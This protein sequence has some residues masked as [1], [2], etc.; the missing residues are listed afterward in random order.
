[1]IAF[2][3]E[4]GF[5]VAYVL[6]ATIK[7]NIVFGLK[8]DGSVDELLDYDLEETI[9]NVH[10]VLT[11]DAVLTA[12]EAADIVTFI[13][14]NSGAAKTIVT[15]TTEYTV[16]NDPSNYKIN[17]DLWHKSNARASVK[18]KFISSSWTAL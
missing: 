9:N 4:A 1:M 3:G 7:C 13:T 15:D 17:F 11:V 5:N 18:L 12:A 16:V 6:A 10:R 2:A 8:I 14:D